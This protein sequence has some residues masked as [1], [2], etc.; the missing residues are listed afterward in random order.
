VPTLPEEHSDANCT[1]S[2]KASS[3]PPD[4]STDIKRNGTISVHQSENFVLPSTVGAKSALPSVLAGR[5]RE[6]M[7][8]YSPRAKK[9][10]PESSAQLG[11]PVTPSEPTTPAGSSA[12]ARRK[13]NFSLESDAANE[14]KVSLG[15][16]AS[17][18]LLQEK[19]SAP[20][21]SRP[22]DLAEIPVYLTEVQRDIFFSPLRPLFNNAKDGLYQCSECG[23]VLKSL[24]EGRRHMVSHIRVMRIRC[25]LCDAGA[26]F[27]SDMRLHLMYRHCENLHM[28]PE[29]YVLPGKEVPCM[30]KKQADELTRLVDSQNP[31]RVMYTSGK[32][33][34]CTNHKPYTPDPDIEA[35]IL[36]A[37][38]LP[39][40]PRKPTQGS[41][42]G[43]S[44]VASVSG[45]PSS[46][47]VS[48]QT[49]KPQ[50][51]T[52]TTTTN[53]EIRS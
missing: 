24:L 2:N 21:N 27:C 36:G 30:T 49:A 29:G 8:F 5:V 35:R 25:S 1:L 16:G 45:V 39:R 51:T 33:V 41:S 3:A 37:H 19:S 48:K 17:K 12:T 47:T 38:R 44:T 9:S 28:A 10:A 46:S 11:S 40:T 18:K 26:F 53:N 14:V 13:Q 7:S 15:N 43:S 22:D 4:P 42:T 52:S 34:S 23:A 50:Q 31:G 6:D 32:I 20:T